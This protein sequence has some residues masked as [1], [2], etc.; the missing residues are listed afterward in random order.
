MLNDR[1][2]DRKACRT[3]GVMCRLMAIHGGGYMALLPVE[4][5]RDVNGG[6][7]FGYVDAGCIFGA[8]PGHGCVG[9]STSPQQ[10]RIW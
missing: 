1:G 10:N 5:S 9:S 7:S 2:V 4:S 6:K 8:F 3:H